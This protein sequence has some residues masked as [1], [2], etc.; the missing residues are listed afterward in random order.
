[1]QNEKLYP[2]GTVYWIIENEK[3][4]Y[5]DARD[6]DEAEGSNK[7]EEKASDVKGN[8]NEKECN[9][10][11]DDDIFEKKGNIT[12]S[13]DKQYIM[14]EIDDESKI[15]E[16]IWFSSHMYG[17][18]RVASTSK[19]IRI[20]TNNSLRLHPKFGKN[21]NLPIDDEFK[22]RLK[23]LLHNFQ[24]PIRYV[25]A[26]G[27]GVFPQQGYDK[28]NKPMIDFIFAV[29]HP[30]H[31]HSLNINQNRNHYSFMGTLGSGAITILQEKFGAGIYYNPYVKVE[32]TL[33]KYG[34]VSIDKMC[35]D[36][37]NWETLYLAGRM[38]KP[39]KILSDDAR[40]RLAQQVNL[41]SAL[42]TALLLLPKDF[43]EEE[44]YLTISSISFKGDFRK[45]FGENPNK[46]RNVVSRQMNNFNL[47]YG[48]LIQ[49]LPIVDFV[50]NGK[51]QQDDSPK[52]RAQM[53]QKLPRTLKYKVQEEHRMVLA[54]KG[55]HWPSGLRDIIFK[56][57]LSQSLK[58]ILTA[59]LSKSTTYACSKIGKWIRRPT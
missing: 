8:G 39:V 3:K 49:G 13:S 24:A 37:L 5:C 40:V 34:V 43:T 20:T 6:D 2:P 44:L 48:G 15:F 56:P 41:A 26:Y 10:N 55:I 50:A 27:S 19:Q 32:D 7:E 36:L 23:K 16:K 38:H 28:K 46:I 31:W 59:G 29:G 53:I 18:L 11:N 33:I 21:Q 9:V 54:G 1:M 22:E 57:V 12:R 4:P 30:Q 35:K 52:A 47:L 42:R 58:G 45:Y 17:K 14:L 25:I 51:L